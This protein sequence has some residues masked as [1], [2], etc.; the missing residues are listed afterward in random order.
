MDASRACCSS[1]QSFSGLRLNKAFVQLFFGSLDPARF[2][3]SL[4]IEGRRRTAVESTMDRLFIRP[5]V[6][7]IW[8]SE[9]MTRG[10]GRAA[11][12]FPVVKLPVTIGRRGFGLTGLDCQNQWRSLWCAIRR[13]PSELP[14]LRRDNYSQRNRRRATRQLASTSAFCDIDLVSDATNADEMR[15]N[16]LRKHSP[17]DLEVRTE[18]A[19]VDRFEQA[20]SLLA[21]RRRQT[22]SQGIV[23]CR[24]VVYP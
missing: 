4:P 16:S 23:F 12:R 19:R 8:L 22:S 20:Q 18:R 10:N 1:C 2:Y 5:S 7:P 15:L 21:F 17:S 6:S 14:S 13:K 3:A 11:C 24:S 9:I